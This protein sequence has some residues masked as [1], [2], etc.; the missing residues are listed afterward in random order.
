MICYITG[1]ECV[2]SFPDEGEC[3]YD[4]LTSDY[5][6]HEDDD[7]LEEYIDAAYQEKIHHNYEDCT[8][9]F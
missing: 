3:P 2:C 6:H 9:R 8:E 1:D 4:T 5:D 7:N